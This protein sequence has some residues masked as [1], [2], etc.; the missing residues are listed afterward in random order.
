VAECQIAPYH[1]PSPEREN[2]SGADTKL[3]DDSV[4]RKARLVVTFP[5][6]LK[7]PVRGA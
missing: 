2:N 4:L 1:F 6:G 3:P 5:V 7:V